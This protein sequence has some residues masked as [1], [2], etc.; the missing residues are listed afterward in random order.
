[1]LLH[2]IG[3]Y[4]QNKRQITN[5]FCIDGVGAFLNPLQALGYDGKYL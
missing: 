2:K 4:M 3:T 5:L 1:M